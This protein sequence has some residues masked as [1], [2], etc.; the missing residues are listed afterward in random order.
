MRLTQGLLFVGF[1]GPPD[2]V[3]LPGCLPAPRR[4]A[5]GLLGWFRGPILPVSRLGHRLASRRFAVG[6][7][8]RGSVQL[9]QRLLLGRFW[10]PLVP[11]SRPEQLL[12]PRLFAAGFA[13]LWG[14]GWLSPGTLLGGFWGLHILV[15]PRRFV[16]GFVEL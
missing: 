11:I 13:G 2:P 8:G 7:L 16:P 12:A 3:S 14:G 4:S 5:V 10:G 9:T 15:F 1:R 6:L